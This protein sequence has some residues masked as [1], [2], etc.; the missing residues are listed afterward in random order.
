MKLSIIPQK[1]GDSFNWVN[2]QVVEVVS[3]NDLASTITAQHYSG[4]LFK[5]NYCNTFNFIS[6]EFIILDYDN[7]PNEPQLS[8]DDARAKFSTYKHIIA[9]TK[10]HQIEKSGSPPADRYR[11]VLF[12]STTITDGETFAATWHA[13]RDMFPGCDESAK[14]P[15]RRLFSSVNVISVNDSGQLIQP[16]ET[17]V[18]APKK[19]FV[20]LPEGVKGKLARDVKDFMLEGIEHGWNDM[21]YKAAKDH[22]QNNYSKEEFIE[23][24]TRITGHLDRKDTINHVVNNTPPRL[25]LSYPLRGH[26]FAIE[27]PTDLTRGEADELCGFI[28]RFGK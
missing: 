11:V 22:Q 23:R 12:L 25:T 1:P 6:T 27:L 13:V 21:L 28:T 2:T 15:S 19:E 17:A 9:T 26:T 5:D 4:S 20:Q 16:V 18:K 8:L 24:A 14:D 10:S 7:K 3:V